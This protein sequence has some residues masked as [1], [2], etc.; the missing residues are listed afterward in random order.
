MVETAIF[1]DY[2]MAGNMYVGPKNQNTLKLMTKSFFFLRGSMIIPFPV[3][4]CYRQAAILLQLLGI[5]I[6]ISPP[7]H[8]PYLLYPRPQVGKR[9]NKKSLFMNQLGPLFHACS[10]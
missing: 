7:Y 3:G 8:T 2:E 4:F 5:T 9:Y 10:I 1:E 6:I